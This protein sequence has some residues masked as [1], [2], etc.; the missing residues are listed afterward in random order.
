M[1]MYVCFCEENASVSLGLIISLKRGCFE[2]EQFHCK[3]E[4]KGY[5]MIPQDACVSQH[6]LA[7]AQHSN[8]L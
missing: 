5:N 3:S 8:R 4:H 6:W 2:T 7:R 1:C